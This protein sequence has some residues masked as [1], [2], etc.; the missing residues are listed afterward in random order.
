MFEPFRVVTHVVCEP[1]LSDSFFFFLKCEPLTEVACRWTMIECIWVVFFFTIKCKLL[2]GLFPL[3]VLKGA[4]L[5]IFIK[6]NLSRYLTE[7]VDHSTTA[8][9]A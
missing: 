8:D 5:N 4:Q 6:A 7:Q 3:I 2:L 1:H 9:V